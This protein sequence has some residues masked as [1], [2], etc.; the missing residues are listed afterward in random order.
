MPRRPVEAPEPL[1]GLRPA[2]KRPC[3]RCDYYEATRFGRA[4][5][6][7]GD[8][9][10]RWMEVGLCERCAAVCAAPGYGSRSALSTTHT[11][12]AK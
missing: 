8:R 3:D 5:V 12:H 2:W 6:K 10:T 9:S 4:Q 1:H 11:V 7:E